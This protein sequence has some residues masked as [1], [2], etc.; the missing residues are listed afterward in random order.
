MTRICCC[1]TDEAAGLALQ[2]LLPVVGCF[3]RA[4]GVHVE[5]IDV[6]LAV[7]ILAAFPEALLA[8]QRVDD[9][10]A[11]LARRVLQPD[12]VVVKPPGISASVE[13]IGAAV[14][15]LQ[16]HGFPLPDHPDAPATAA[17][18]AV[19]ARY[20]AIR[21]SVVNTVLRQGTSVRR[22]PEIVKQ[23]ARGRPR[24]VRSFEGMRS[25]VASLAAG[26]FRATEQ[27]LTMQ[28]DAVLRIEHHA[29]D[30]CVKLLH[31][32]LQVRGDDVVDAAVLR[33]SALEPFL[34]EV[35]E[36]CRREHL[37]F[38]LPL[39][40]TSLRVS[41]PA[42]FGEAVQAHYAPVIKRYRAAFEAAGVAASSGFQAFLPLAARDEGMAQS[43]EA[44][45]RH[46]PALAMLDPGAGHSTLH[47]PG[48]TSIAAFMAAAMARG[49]RCIGPDGCLRDTTF[50]IPDRGESGF[51]RV[52]LEDA[53]ANG[54]MD[55]AR[56]G[57]VTTVGLTA[58]A[59]DEYGAQDTTFR[60]D[61]GG[62]VRV[63][64]AQGRVLL[65]HAVAEGD[66]WR[67]CRRSRQAIRDWIAQALAVGRPGAPVVFWLDASRPRDRE[68]LRHLHGLHPK[69]QW[70]ARRI[71]VQ[72]VE[73][74]TAF[75]L[76]R[77][78][79]GQD[80]VAATGNLLR[81]YIGEF[82][83]RIEAGSSALVEV[84]T[85]LLA[86]GALFEAGACGCAPAIA[87]DFVASNHLRWNPLADLF[88]WRAALQALAH[89]GHAPAGAL[90]RALDRATSSLLSQGLLP[91]RCGLDLRQTVFHLAR[92]WAIEMS[93]TTG[94][95]AAFAALASRLQRE[96]PLIE[97]ELA[98]AAGQTVD[99]GGYYWPDQQRL[100]AA[101]NA[102]SALSAALQGLGAPPDDDSSARPSAK[103]SGLVQ[104]A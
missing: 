36:T 41:D 34:A 40:C 86:G 37:L 61:R 9:T 83:G 91:S 54:P 28:G 53:Q 49:G 24:P 71:V 70:S 95:A 80:V 58:D 21:G 82:F 73:R 87:R 19:R 5:V 26:D 99:L 94:T 69:E 101:L 100:A 56:I 93:G 22:V 104:C 47:A 76:D 42:I 102:S 16:R 33:R 68:T 57:S 1:H 20:D 48:G 79:T 15:E 46:G 11:R 63:V 89:G 66:V 62:S 12:A 10:V 4:C 72:D 78:R 23:W 81:D 13:Q 35:L 2:A 31:E 52:L 97:R 44:V 32:G 18:A 39:K 43:I 88:A 17:Q 75:T 85:R 74:A 45:H 51:Y 96:G 14:A 30:G 25:C 8:G 64:D 59:A 38:A 3:A 84:G 98:E 103:K 50:V 27:A 6:S 29:A 77:L 65:Q 55:A 7:R 67:L 90:A 92:L 60:I